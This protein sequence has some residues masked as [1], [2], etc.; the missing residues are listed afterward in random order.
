MM[1]VVHISAAAAQSVGTK[2]MRLVLARQRNDARLR[3]NLSAV[4]AEFGVLNSIQLD[5]MFFIKLTHITHVADAYISGFYM[6]VLTGICVSAT[7]NAVIKS[8]LFQTREGIFACP[9]Q[10]AG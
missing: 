3:E 1:T 5:M 7:A 8:V 10:F 6:L 2:M 4:R 9:N